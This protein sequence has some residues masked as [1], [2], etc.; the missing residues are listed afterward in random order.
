MSPEDR[1]SLYID[2]L[3]EGRRPPRSEGDEEWELL[4]E[5]VRRV[6]RLAPPAMPER[7]F[8]QRLAAALSR[9]L[10]GRRAGAR[11]GLRGM[12]AFLGTAA[13]VLVLCFASYG[14]GRWSVEGRWPWWPLSAAPTSQERAPVE[15]GAPES[16]SL[17]NPAAETGDRARASE[18][19][20]AAPPV[21]ADRVRAGPATGREEPAA[22]VPEAPSVAGAPAD[23]GGGGTV[24]GGP[25]PGNGTPA[26]PVG[27]APEKT[28]GYFAAS[29]AGE[30]EARRLNEVPETDGAPA[31]TPAPPAKGTPA[32]GTGITLLFEGREYRA[33]ELLNAGELP[34]A[35]FELLGEGRARGLP[36]G[37]RVPVYRRPDSVPTEVY[38]P[39]G[40]LW[41]RWAPAEPPA[42][43]SPIREP[44]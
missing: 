36:D 6:R 3:I 34:A 16:P 24:E 14:Y 33:V 13:A 27:A 37:E 42:R 28:Q 4:L 41:V 2:A 30:E 35:R 25:A 10:L 20:G 21:A 1:L 43:G 23:R 44:R 12:T 32:A 17:P 7:D 19:R 11:W 9:E 31:Q 39:L 8:P 40:E 18:Q 26:A 38:T 22:P 29:R 5:S 15:R